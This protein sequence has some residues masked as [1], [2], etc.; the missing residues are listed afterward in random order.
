MLISKRNIRLETNTFIDEF[1]TIY[2]TLFENKAFTENGFESNG[3]KI[4]KRKDDYYI[5][6]KTTG[7]IVTWYKLLGWNLCCNT[8]MKDSDWVD[9]CNRLRADLEANKIN[10]ISITESVDFGERND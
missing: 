5:V 1:Y 6:D 3:F 10:I 7:I 2:H 9:F 8:P 4:W